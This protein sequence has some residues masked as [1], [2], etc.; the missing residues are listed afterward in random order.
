MKGLSHMLEKIGDKTFALLLLSS[1]LTFSVGYST[2]LAVKWVYGLPE[3]RCDN[4]S[5]EKLDPNEE[6]AFPS[7]EKQVC[8]FIPSNKEITVYNLD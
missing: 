4:A 3:V 7:D 6:D 8:F 5:W 1:I 2:G